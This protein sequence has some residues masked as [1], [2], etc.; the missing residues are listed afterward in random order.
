MP[1]A[2]MLGPHLASVGVVAIVAGLV[3]RFMVARNMSFA[4][5]ALAEVGF[6]GSAGPS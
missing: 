5:H 6:T 1:T 2:F 3:S 4:V